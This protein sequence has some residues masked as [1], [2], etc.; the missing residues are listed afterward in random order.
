MQAYIGNWEDGKFHG[1]GTIIL[2]GGKI[3]RGIFEK[4]K[5]IKKISF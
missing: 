3:V 1:E 2:K 5:L 4:G